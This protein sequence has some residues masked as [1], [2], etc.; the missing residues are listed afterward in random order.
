MLP[1]FLAAQC[2]RLA[3]PAPPSSPTRSSAKRGRRLPKRSPGT[4]VDSGSEVLGE[5]HA[6]GLLPRGL[7]PMFQ[8]FR[9]RP[10]GGR[11][12]VLS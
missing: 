2:R 3:M 8:V 5:T 1:A 9:T 12:L 10:A 6:T 4:L 11:V 7:T